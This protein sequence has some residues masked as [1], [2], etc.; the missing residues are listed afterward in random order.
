[1]TGALRNCGIDFELGV[2]T[3]SLSESNETPEDPLEEDTF[4]PKESFK[5]F[6]ARFHQ[7]AP[8]AIVLANSSDH[9]DDE[10]TSALEAAASK[11]HNRA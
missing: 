4:K 3:P 6:L 8:Q 11:P 9:S 1:M 2:P 5:E 7:K 10:Q